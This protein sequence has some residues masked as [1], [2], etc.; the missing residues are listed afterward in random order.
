MRF[1]FAA[2]LIAFPRFRTV[3]SCKPIRWWCPSPRRLEFAS[4]RAASPPRCRALC[5]DIYTSRTRAA[6]GQPRMNDVAHADPTATPLI[7]ATSQP[8]ENAVH[9]REAGLRRD[10]DFVR[11]FAAR[12]VPNISWC[13]PTSGEG[14]AR[15]HRAGEA[16]QGPLLLR[17]GGQRQRRPPGDGDLKA[18]FRAQSSTYLTRAPAEPDRPDCRAARMPPRPARRR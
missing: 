10:R 18:A 8:G 3:L 1:V 11:R 9:D 17:L 7:T 5:R 2:C 6:A 16:K 14:P 12:Q 4:W 13:T 15:V